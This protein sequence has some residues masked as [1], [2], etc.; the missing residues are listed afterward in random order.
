MFKMLQQTGLL[1]SLK[2]LMGKWVNLPEGVQF[3]GAR[4]ELT[5]ALGVKTEHRHEK[6]MI[7]SLQYFQKD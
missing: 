2:E 1:Q 4:G 3:T 5:P 6:M 7:L